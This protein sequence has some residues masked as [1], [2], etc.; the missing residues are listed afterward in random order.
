[1]TRVKGSVLPP[2]IGEDPWP[3]RFTS[4]GFARAGPPRPPDSLPPR[5]PP[6]TAER[7]RNIARHYQALADHLTELG[8]TRAAA[9]AMRDSKWWHAR[10]VSLGRSDD[11]PPPG[12]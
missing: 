7:A 1:M 5:T 4:R 10:A 11:A 3:A 6:I 9:I 12:A 2:Q 8:I